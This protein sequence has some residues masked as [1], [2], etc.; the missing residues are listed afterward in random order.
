MSEKPENNG[1]EI[2]D[3]YLEMMI[4][5]AA[6]YDNDGEPIYDDEPERQDCSYCGG[7][8]TDRY[9]GLDCPH[10]DGMGYEWW[11]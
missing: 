10:C 2:T 4:Q 7:T 1:R 9:D 8:G 11:W 6:D 3:E 5:D